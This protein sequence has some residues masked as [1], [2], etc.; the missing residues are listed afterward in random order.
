MSTPAAVVSGG[1][2]NLPGQLEALA[3]NLLTAK[4]IEAAGAQP[5]QLARAQKIKAI[6]VELDGVALGTVTLQQVAATVEASAGS[7]S[8]PVSTQIAVQGLFGI[9]VAGLPTPP[10]SGL[11]ATAQAAIA[12]QFLQNVIA[13]AARYGA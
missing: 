10:S 1:I 8:A 3:A 11:L 5:L 13:T 6:A 9:V 4:F 2:L 12:N 7:A